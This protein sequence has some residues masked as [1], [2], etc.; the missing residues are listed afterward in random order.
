MLTLLLHFKSVAL[1]FWKF[2]S[3]LASLYTFLS[4]LPEIIGTIIKTDEKVEI[5]NMEEYIEQYDMSVS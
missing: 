2:I 5:K 3:L 1:T 4:E